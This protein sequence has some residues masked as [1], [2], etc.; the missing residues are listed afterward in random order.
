MGDSR[1]TGSTTQPAVACE[2]C[3][4]ARICFP[5]A[6]PLHE[7]PRFSRLVRRGRTLSAGLHLCRAGDELQAVYIVRA[8]T[9][10]V[11]HT[12]PAGAESVVGFC[13][14][15]EVVG[16][17][18]IAN[19]RHA[20]DVIALEHSSY[21]ALSLDKLQQL[22]EQTP[23]MRQELIRVMSRTLGETHQR[24]TLL[25]RQGARALVA[26]FVLDLSVRLERRGLASSRFRLGMRWRDVA[27]YLGLTFET[28][29]RSLAA[30]R[31]SGVLQAKARYLTVM[32]RTLLENV[33]GGAG[34]GDQKPS[35]VIP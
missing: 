16:L 20:H 35:G 1:Q 27:S 31:R 9:L 25:A 18:A 5:A 19:Q 11:V 10:K 23:G 3:G 17:D 24:M 33:A 14:P 22:V 13:L 12:T 4:L 15:G 26:A 6:L 32:N 8:G 2:Q 21:C 34:C 29:S 30:L 28:V 7:I